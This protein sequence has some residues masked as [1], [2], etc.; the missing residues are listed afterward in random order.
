MKNIK[1][2]HIVQQKCNSFKHVVDMLHFVKL[3]EFFLLF[4]LSSDQSN[5]VDSLYGKSNEM[6]CVF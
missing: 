2:Q 5:M 1:V 4:Y 3:I 6:S